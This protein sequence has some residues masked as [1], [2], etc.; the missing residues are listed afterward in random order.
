M[1]AHGHGDILAPLV[2]HDDPL[3]PRS[4]DA[5]VAAP[6]LGRDVER[7]RRGAEHHRGEEVE[8]DVFAVHDRINIELDI[9]RHEAR[10]HEEQLRRG[11]EELW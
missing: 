6:I 9:S 5:G 10:E 3:S 1:A 2:L 11:E 7:E 4:G 8:R